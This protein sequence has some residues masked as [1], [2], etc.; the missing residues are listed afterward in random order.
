LKIADRAWIQR[1]ARQNPVSNTG[2]QNGDHAQRRGERPWKEDFVL[3]AR[4]RPRHVNA[5]RSAVQTKA[6]GTV[7]SPGFAIAASKTHMNALLTSA[8]NAQSRLWLNPG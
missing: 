1:G 8:E 5:A 2:G 3:P 7:P 6:D 4:Q